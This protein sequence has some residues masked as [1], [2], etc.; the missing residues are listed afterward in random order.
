MGIKDNLMNKMIN[1]ML[2][3]IDF[4]KLQKQ[5]GNGKID[6]KAMQDM[7]S[8]MLGGD[9]VRN[10][11]NAVENE[12]QKKN[13]KNFTKN[14]AKNI[15]CNNNNAVSDKKQDNTNTKKNI[16]ELIKQKT[17]GFEGICEI[18]PQRPPF[19]M[20]DKVIDL[21]ID[22]KKVVCQKCLSANEG[23]FVGH[24]PNNPIM[25]GVLMIEAMAQAASVI[26]KALMADRE[27]V[28]L[29]ASVDNVKFEDVAT[30]G[31]VLIIEAQVTAIRDPLVKG[32]CTVKKEDKIIASCELKAFKK[33]I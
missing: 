7:V 9:A 23:F 13:D 21:D 1:S 10:I 18:I 6:M 33:K 15:D 29:F 17:F 3:K 30:A 5:A 14:D 32:K 2:G 24:F 27:G 19:L 31:D 28:L 16:E 11:Q 8:A 22:K 20:L 25:P 12:V 26:G 4:D